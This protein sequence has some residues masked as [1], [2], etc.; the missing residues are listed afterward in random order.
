MSRPSASRGGAP[1]GFITD[2]GPV[3]TAAVMYMRLWN[4]T[5][6]PTPADTPCPAVPA[7]QEPQAT[8]CFKAICD[9]CTRYGRRPLMRHGVSCKCLGADE[10]CFAHFIGYAHEGAREDALMLAATFV[11]PDVAVHL[12]DLAQNFG[13]ILKRS[14]AP[15]MA[16]A[17]HATPQHQVLH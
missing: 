12:V 4:D 15:S 17:T 10:A 14:T 1:V 2:L 9:L 13:L 11:R 6:G 7:D 16:H 8:A 5:R 3:E